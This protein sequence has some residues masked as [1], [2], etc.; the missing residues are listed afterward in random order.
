MTIQ[1]QLDLVFQE[2]GAKIKA[3]TAQVNGMGG[4]SEYRNPEFTAEDYGFLGWTVTPDICSTQQAMTSGT[5]LLTR[6]KTRAAGNVSEILF[7]VTNAAA[8]LTLA[9]WRIYDTSGALLGE[10]ANISGGLTVGDKV[11]AITTPFAVTKGQELW[12]VFYCTGTTGPTITSTAQIPAVNFG[13]TTSSPVR[14][15]R[16]TGV[17]GDLA[18]VVKTD[19]VGYSNQIPL[20]VL[21]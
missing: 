12:V 21:R 7:R 10:T 17:T 3:L 19:Y 13:L 15:G 5:A 18:T 9:R 14:T 1:A 4:G 8:S 20:A 2:I 6:M 16:K 11:V